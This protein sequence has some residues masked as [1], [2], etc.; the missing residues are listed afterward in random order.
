[1]EFLEKDKPILTIITVVYN[2]RLGLEC[3]R[4]SIRAQ[5]FKNWE[6]IVVDGLSTDDTL[7]ALDELRCDPRV[8]VVSER[9][10]GLYDAMN[11][12][13]SRASGAYL[14]FLNAGDCYLNDRSLEQCCIDLDTERVDILFASRMVTFGD[15]HRRRIPVRRNS[16][17]IYHGLPTSHQACFVRTELQV[18]FP[19]D[20]KYLISA[21]YNCIARIVSHG[22]QLEYSDVEVVL[23]D[24]GPN[25]LSF[26]NPFKVIT[27]CARTQR[28]VFKMPLHKVIFSALRRLCPMALRRGY[29]IVLRLPIIGYMLR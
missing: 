28:V 9:D 16:D 27:E 26:K 7:V 18:A 21:D 5:S 15:G 6:W 4:D 1:M 23:S 20:L 19:Y 3:T 22:A 12:G 25:S 24:L 13:A 10:N 8:T 14:N 29:V 2:D 11:K 17:Y